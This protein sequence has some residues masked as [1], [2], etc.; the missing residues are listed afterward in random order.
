[1]TSLWLVCTS[2]RGPLTDPNYLKSLVA[3]LREIARRPDAG[4]RDRKQPKIDALREYKEEILEAHR[5]GVSVH[6]IAQIF[7][8]R[9]VDISVP[10]LVRTMARFIN[11]EDRAGGR[12]LAAQNRPVIQGSA[13][14]NAPATYQVSDQPSLSR[15]TC[16]SE[17]HV[18]TMK[19]RKPQQPPRFPFCAVLK[20]PISRLEGTSGI[21][22]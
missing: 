16:R 7:R 18:D 8:E 5:S 21:R 1:M 3:N 9:G 15:L 13:K 2:S 22:C 12:S 19:P 11:E 4:R 20:Q 14:P 10:H 6:R 17:I